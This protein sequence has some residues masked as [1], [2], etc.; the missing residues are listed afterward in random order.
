M[1]IKAQENDREKIMKYLLIEPAINLFLIGDIENFGFSQTFQEIWFQE[2][3]N[4]IV[5]VVLRYHSTLIIYSMDLN[6]DFD[7]IKIIL[8]ES[9]IDSISGKY[10][11]MNKIYILNSK[12]FIRKDMKFCQ[13]K[14]QLIVNNSEGIV[15]AKEEDAMEIAIAYG[16]IDEFKVLYSSNVM[17]RYEQI[18]TRIKLKE[19]KHIFIKDSKGIVAHGNTTAENS[20]SSMIGGIF[21]RV[22]KRN[23]G[24]SKRIIS[25]LINDLVNR[26]KTINLIYSDEMIGMV[27]KKNGFEI[28]GNWTILGRKLDE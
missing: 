6:M 9:S 27:F 1:L 23:Q 12:D 21:T 5:G 7:L 4:N 25:E 22:D 19:G 8:N 24:Y 2:K 17:T 26:N 3:D 20:I 28:I 15:I 10:E 14:N 11:V 18:K 13:Y 16:E